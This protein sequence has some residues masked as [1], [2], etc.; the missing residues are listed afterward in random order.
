M[1]IVLFGTVPD[2][3]KK[4]YRG[5]DEKESVKQSLTKEINRAFCGDPNPF[6][7]KVI[8]SFEVSKIH[9]HRIMCAKKS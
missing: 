3:M 5:A 8:C 9:N 6:F 7:L 2:N 4:Y 1:L